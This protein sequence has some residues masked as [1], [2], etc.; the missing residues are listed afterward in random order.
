MGAR[1]TTLPLLWE[2]ILRQDYPHDKFEW[3]I[4]TDNDD[5][6]EFLKNKLSAGS[7]RGIKIKIKH[8]PQKLPIGAKRNSVITWQMV[9][10]SLTWMMMTTTFLRGFRHCVDK[11]KGSEFVVHNNYQYTFLM[12]NQ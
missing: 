9:K 12:I 3:I 8:T 4:V 11:L 1:F 6:T 2:W 5:E 10:S 7:S